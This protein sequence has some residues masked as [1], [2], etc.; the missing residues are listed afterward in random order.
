[1]P[2]FRLHRGGLAES[3]QTTIIVLN[4]LEILH[5]FAKNHGSLISD[6]CAHCT[7]KDLEIKPYPNDKDNFD[8]RI[9]WFT[10]VVRLKHADDKYY[11]IGFLS[12]P[13]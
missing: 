11:V 1:M 2:L 6:M 5:Y 12:E 4:H 10:Q 3:L 9:G 8:A 7:I 13:L